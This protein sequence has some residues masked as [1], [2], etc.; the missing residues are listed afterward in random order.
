MRSGVGKV[1]QASN[2]LVLDSEGSY[3]EDRITGE[4]ITLRHV[5]FMFL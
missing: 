4:K 2:K 3:S 1:V 5:F